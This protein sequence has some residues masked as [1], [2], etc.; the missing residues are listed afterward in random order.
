MARY[1]LFIAVNF[2]LH[3]LTI[4]KIYYYENQDRRR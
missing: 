4:I 3:L 1:P 2:F